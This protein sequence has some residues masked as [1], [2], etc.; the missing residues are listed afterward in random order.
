MQGACKC[1]PPLGVE[2]GRATRC[3][4]AARNC[5]AAEGLSTPCQCE[6]SCGARLLTVYSVI[7]LIVR[8]CN[9]CLQGTSLFGLYAAALLA[10]IPLPCYE[11]A[12]YAASLALLRRSTTARPSAAPYIALT[13]KAA[14]E[15]LMNCACTRVLCVCPASL[16]LLRRST[17]ARPSAAR[18]IALTGKTAHLSMRCAYMLVVA[19][20]CAACLPLH[21]A[22]HQPLLPAMRR[23]AGVHLSACT[24]LHYTHPPAATVQACTTWLASSI[25]LLLPL[26][27]RRPAAVHRLRVWLNRAAPAARAVQASQGCRPLRPA[28][29]VCP[30]VWRS[31]CAAAGV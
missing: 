30:A 15:L 29:R 24:L 4:A 27:A 23:A 3:T 25:P 22:R 28:R 1:K 16:A 8:S 17:T 2:A 31:G 10:L 11:A 21:K 20:C 13:G 5:A 12:G 19:A 26:I 9:P 6:P 18:Y 14:H 7:R